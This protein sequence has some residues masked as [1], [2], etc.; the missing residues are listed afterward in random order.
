MN[1]MHAGVDFAIPVGTALGSLVDGKARLK[2]QPGTGWGSYVELLENNQVAWR[3]AHLDT[4]KTTPLYA[5]VAAGGLRDVKKGE[6]IAYSGMSGTSNAHLHL[7]RV[8]SGNRVSPLSAFPYAGRDPEKPKLAPGATLT[9]SGTAVSMNL[10]VKAPDWDLAG[11][12]INWWNSTA[13]ATS[14]AHMCG[15]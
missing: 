12:L 8:E 10:T 15:S 11:V 13:V 1:H 7:E 4:D 5:S 6:L 9:A 2:F 14:S 3:Y